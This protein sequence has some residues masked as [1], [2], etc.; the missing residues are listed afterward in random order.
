L[1]ELVTSALR[2]VFHNCGRDTDD[3]VQ[4][5]RRHEE[6]YH[7]DTKLLFG[8]QWQMVETSDYDKLMNIELPAT[9]PELN[10]LFFLIV[11]DEQLSGNWKQL[12]GWEN[13]WVDSGRDQA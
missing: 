1:G 11:D 7:R 10:L 6:E 4:W 5:H 9:E 2:T 8:D 12:F 3:G 13:G